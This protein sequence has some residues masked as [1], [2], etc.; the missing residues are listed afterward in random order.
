MKFLG[1]IGGSLV[2]ASD[3]FAAFISAGYGAS[4]SKLR[5][6][7]SKIQSLKKHGRVKQE[8]ERSRRQRYYNFVQYLKQDGL[9][10]EK[11]KKGN[12]FFL[13]TTKGCN[14][15]DILKERYRHRLP[16]LVYKKEIGSIFVIVAFD[17]PEKERRKRDWLRSA[18]HNLGLKKIQRSLWLGKI[19]IPSNFLDDLNR[20][21]LT[22]DVEI[23]EVSKTGTLRHLI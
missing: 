11:I 7:F 20:L 17:I 13:L 8:V 9:V 3:F 14:R 21:H 2:V 19:K 22:D 16:A 23:F 6:E 4:Q 15:L 12:K 10:E 1:K 5:Y 18:L